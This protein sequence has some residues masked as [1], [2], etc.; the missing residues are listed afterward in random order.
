M[1]RRSH[2]AES[3]SR[4]IVAMIVVLIGA[5]A[6]IFAFSMFNDTGCATYLPSCNHHVTPAQ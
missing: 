5:G 2:A 1:N 6:V 4:F 3:F